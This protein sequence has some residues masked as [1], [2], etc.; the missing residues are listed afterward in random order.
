M[1]SI[2]TSDQKIAE[3]EKTS[4]LAAVRETKTC[5]NVVQFV[6]YRE[7]QWFNREEMWHGFSF[8]M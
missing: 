7:E 2:Y 5:P 4:W 3:E 8:A 6:L 1:R